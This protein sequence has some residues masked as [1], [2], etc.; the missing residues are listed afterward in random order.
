MASFNFIYVLSALRPNTATW[1]V[2]A[3]AYDL[4]ARGN[5][6]S[7]RGVWNGRK[8]VDTIALRENWGQIVKGLYS[9]FI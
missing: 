1:R 5:T 7:L 8:V 6:I 9:I 3:S 2:R 4:G